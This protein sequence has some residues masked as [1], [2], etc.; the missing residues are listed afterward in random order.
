MED[1]ITINC[2][3]FVKQNN[4][5]LFG[6]SITQEEKTKIDIL[7]MNVWESPWSPNW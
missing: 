1:E 7:P 5:S 4:Y 6:L 3:F 2:N